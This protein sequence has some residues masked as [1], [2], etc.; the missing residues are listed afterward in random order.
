[1]A[2]D[3]PYETQHYRYQ[4]MP[5]VRFDRQDNQPYAQMPAPNHKNEAGGDTDTTSGKGEATKNTKGGPHSLCLNTHN[6]H[7]W[8][9][10]IHH[11]Y[12]LTINTR[13]DH[14]AAV[15]WVEYDGQG[16]PQ[17][18]MDECC[19]HLTTP[20]MRHEQVTAHGLDGILR[21]PMAKP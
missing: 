12:P 13:C 5:R 19:A 16:I 7:H 17:E 11:Q 18:R 9:H 6:I 20:H 8:C 1:M 10:G 21:T 3:R 14:T 2:P 15:N 4:P